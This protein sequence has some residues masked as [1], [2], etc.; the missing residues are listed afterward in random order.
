MKLNIVII[1]VF[2]TAALVGAYKNYNSAES[3]FDITAAT[4]KHAAQTRGRIPSGWA[5]PYPTPRFD[6]ASYIPKPRPGITVRVSGHDGEDYA[7]KLQAAHDNPAVGTIIAGPGSLKRPVIF[8]THTKL[9]LPKGTALSCDLVEGIQPYN[10]LIPLTDYGCIL[11]ADGVWVEGTRKAPRE[12]IEAITIG[13]PRNW[14][15]DPHFKKLTALT[16]EQ[17]AGDTGIILEPTYNLGAGRPAIEVF[18]ALGDVLGSHTGKSQNI[19]ITGVVIKGRQTIYDGGVRSSILLGNC[20]NCTIQ[21]VF[22]WNTRSI[23]V[24]SGGSARETNNFSNNVLIWRNS[25]SQVAAANIAIINGEN[26]IAAENYARKLGHKGFGGGISA[27]DI[28]TNS[29]ADHTKNI[30]IINNLADYENASQESA[31]SAFVAQ[32]PFVGM[33]HGEV[34]VA[35]NWA[36][37]GRGEYSDHRYMSN[38]LYLV[39]L[40]QCKVINN[41]VFRTGQNALQAYNLDGCLIQDNDFEHTGGGGN[42]TVALRGVINSVLRRNHFRSRPGLAINA[43]SGLAEEKCSRNNIFDNNLVNG[44]LKPQLPSKCP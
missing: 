7:A 20:H 19:A 8:R 37:G 15:T 44:E 5:T 22:L 43:Q 16:D 23:G 31:G 33:N 13:N 35:N 3:P 28:E 42:S 32:D 40:K 29:P 10:K 1:V 9:D 27:I 14:S 18:Q 21:D 26:V 39:G 6:P 38:G 25:F 34:V 30:W 36:I 2:T 41:Y 17:L 4:E 12:Q 11:L 24:T